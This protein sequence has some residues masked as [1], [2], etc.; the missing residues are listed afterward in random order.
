VIGVVADSRN[1]LRRAAGPTVYFPLGNT[2]NVVTVILRTAGSQ[3][4][5]IS[6]IRQTMREFN[7]TVPTF[8]EVTPIELR[9][10]QMQ[11]ERLLTNL[12][13]VFGAVALLLSSIGIY[14]M[15]AYMVT[16]RTSEIGLRM[17]LGAQRTDVVQIVVRE[18]VVPVA[19]GLAF[20]AA[21]TLV[22]T[23]WVDALLFGVSAHDPWTMVGATVVF[24]VIAAA[25]A[26]GPAWRASR[27]D[28]LRALRVE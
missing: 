21:G 8:G 27:V 19:A 23:R 15:L 12:M 16:R 14:G 3:E 20:G 28:P 26:V 5:L 9:E 4:R 17:A 10:Q 11:Q 25:A 7:A 13:L 22:A 1:V 6:T 18:S 2:G 24:L